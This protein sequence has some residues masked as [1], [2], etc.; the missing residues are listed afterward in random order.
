MNLKHRVY[1]VTAGLLAI[2][3]FG[4]WMLSPEDTSVSAPPQVSAPAGSPIDAEPVCQDW[5]TSDRSDRMALC[6]EFTVGDEYTQDCLAG[7]VDPILCECVASQVVRA[8]RNG[9]RRPDMLWGAYP[10]YLA[11]CGR[12]AAALGLGASR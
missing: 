4:A 5:A 2:G 9:A 11:S 12:V 8:L 7:G 3:M 6:A 1:D 10:D